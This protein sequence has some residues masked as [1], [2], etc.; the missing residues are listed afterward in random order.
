MKS[1]TGTIIIFFLVLIEC[2]ANFTDPD[3]IG[4]MRSTVHAKMELSALVYGNSGS[5]MK[6]AGMAALRFL[7]DYI[8]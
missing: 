8:Y 1:A 7:S 5:P 4:N 3:F 2:R 6:K